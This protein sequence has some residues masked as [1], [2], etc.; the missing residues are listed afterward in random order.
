M[1]LMSKQYQKEMSRTTGRRLIKISCFLLASVTVIGVSVFR[2]VSK[3]LINEAQNQALWEVRLYR[4]QLDQVMIRTASRLEAL[5]ASGSAATRNKIPL[6]EELNRLKNKST[7]V[8]KAW[9]AYPD[10]TV[11]SSSNMAPDSIRNRIW[12]RD[13]LHNRRPESIN[14]SILGRTQVMIG[15]PFIESK[16]SPAIITLFSLYIQ[17][18]R[19]VRAGGVDL[20]ISKAVTDDTGNGINWIWNR[21]PVTVYTPE[22]LFVASPLEEEKRFVP[23]LRDDSE[24]PMVEFFINRPTEEWGVNFYKEFGE[25][26]VGAFLRDNSLG[27]VLTVA[28][29]SEYMLSHVR[30]ITLG[31]MVTTIVFVMVAFFL[32]TSAYSTDLKLKEVER[33]NRKAEFRA[34]QAHVNPHFLF[35]ALDR[36]CSLANKKDYRLI[37]EIVKAIAD[38]FRYTT[39]NPENMVLLSEELNYVKRYIMIQKF[40]FGD[41]FSYEVNVPEDLMNVRVFKFTIQPLVENCFVHGVEQT[42]DPVN[43]K[44]QAEREGKYIKI[45]IQDDGPGIDEKTLKEIKTVLSDVGIESTRRGYQIGLSNIHRRL[46]L[47]YG[48]SSGVT[49]ERKNGLTIVTVTFPWTKTC[50][51]PKNNPL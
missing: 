20:N 10:G 17:G 36:I 44:V 3:T 8:L 33:Q 51:P 15:P 13:F 41:R 5:V 23:G 16:E 12:W 30:R 46:M 25:K 39:R 38:I 14:G 27:L 47:M 18:S 19:L 48:G 28:R 4:E 43:I 2:Q 29:S 1:R 34:L 50:E 7:G 11:I 26:W 45:K 21:A 9:V 40:R 22:G 24:R 31:L 37:P 32:T 6:V 35:N 42:L 49:I